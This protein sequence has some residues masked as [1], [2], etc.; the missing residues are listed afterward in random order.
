M[1]PRHLRALLCQFFA[2]RSI[3][4]VSLRPLKL[5]E[6]AQLSSE[7]RTGKSLAAH[8]ARSV[9]RPAAPVR[10]LAETAA[11]ADRDLT[12][13]KTGKVMLNGLA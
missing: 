2:A 13:P 12:M 3:I 7:K 6:E 11:I 8:V 4:E 1:L 5:T 10:Y 9:T